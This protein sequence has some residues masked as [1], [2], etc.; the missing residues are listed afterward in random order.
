MSKGQVM[1][2]MLLGTWCEANKLLMTPWHSG[3]LFGQGSAYIH[4][5]RHVTL[6]ALFQ[7]QAWPYAPT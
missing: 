7:A 4:H 6:S 1:S 3:V 2:V 5:K